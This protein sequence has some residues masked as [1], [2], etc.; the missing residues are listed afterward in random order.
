M[1]DREGPAGGIVRTLILSRPERRNALSPELLDALSVAVT[2]ASREPELRALVITGDGPAF[3]SGYDL[4]HP[5]A[6][7]APDAPVVRLMA[8]VR[9]CPVPIIARVNGAAFGAGLELAASCDVRIA[10]TSATFCL[11]PAKLGIAYAPDGLARLVSLVGTSAARRLVFTGKVVDSAEAERIGLVDEV[12]AD[13]ADLDARVERL[14]DALASAAPLAVRAMKRT[15]N[16]LESTVGAEDRLLAEDDR[17]VC[18][19]SSDSAEGV[20]AFRDRRP[21]RFRGR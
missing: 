9:R 6:G 15:F 8:K 12:A 17:R 3:C 21:P 20:A 5:L 7:E 19:S 13:E 10:A 1:R 16:A 11:P 14:A 4:G 18:F 2:T